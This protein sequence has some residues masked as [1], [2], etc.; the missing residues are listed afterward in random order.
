MPSV[1]SRIYH[2]PNTCD[3]ATQHNTA[4]VG[5]HMAFSV[6]VWLAQVL[7]CCE[8]KEHAECNQQDV[9][10]AQHLQDCGIVSEGTNAAALGEFTASEGGQVQG[11]CSMNG[12]VRKAL[13]SASAQTQ[14]PGIVSP[15]PS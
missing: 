13:A 3:T 8:D 1:I 2:R 14:N 7:H 15:A 4:D 6:S 10:Q 11:T 5:D 12:L 9:P